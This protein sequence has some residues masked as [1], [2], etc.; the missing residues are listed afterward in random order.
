MQ[1]LSIRFINDRVQTALPIDPGQ[2]QRHQDRAARNNC[3]PWRRL[4]QENRID[5][6]ETGRLCR[7]ERGQGSED[8]H[9][10]AR[11]DEH[12]TRDH[13]RAAGGA[14]AGCVEIQWARARNSASLISL[15]WN[16]GIP[17]APLRAKLIKT[18]SGKC[19]PRNSGA[20]IGPAWQ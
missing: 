12:P 13:G 14:G 3:A 7:R 6:K 20:F 4:C 2:Q 16:G 9:A 11:A 1:H 10:R 5:D 17:A 15:G 18:A 8:G 19:R